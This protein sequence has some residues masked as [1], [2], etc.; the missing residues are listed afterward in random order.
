[1][2]YIF[3]L[4]RSSGIRSRCLSGRSSSTPSGLCGLSCSLVWAFGHV[5][6]FFF[7]RSCCCRGSWSSLSSRSRRWL[8]CWSGSRLLSWCCLCWLLSCRSSLLSW[9]RSNRCLRRW[10]LLFCHNLPIIVILVIILLQ[11]LSSVHPLSHAYSQQ[12]HYYETPHHF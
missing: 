6:V 7:G 11:H 5:L 8:S 10:S 1:M 3:L 9:L 2:D 4:G 12:S